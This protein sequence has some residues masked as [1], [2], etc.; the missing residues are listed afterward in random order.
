MEIEKIFPKQSHWCIFCNVQG[1]LGA[2]VGLYSTFKR[3][4]VIAKGKGSD[5]ANVDGMICD[6]KKDKE[7]RLIDFISHMT[8]NDKL[9]DG[10]VG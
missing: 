10:G 5:I 7:Y 4:V 1:N 8:E 6:W 2:V 9:M 3:F